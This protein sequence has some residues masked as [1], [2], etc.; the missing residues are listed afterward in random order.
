MKNRSTLLAIGLAIGL[1]GCASN[2]PSAEDD[3]IRFPDLESTYLREGDFVDPNDVLRI[4]EGQHKDQVRLL[5]GHP[6]FSEGIFGVR[7]WDY[8]FNFYTGYANEYITCQYKLLFDREMRVTSTHWRNA[9]CPVLLVPIQVEELAT[10]PRQER[11]TLSGDVLFGFDSN[12]LTFEGRR[13]LERVVDAFH[14]T[15]A[16]ASIR[17]AGYADR[18]GDEQYNLRLSQERAETVGN[19]LVN[20]GVERASLNMVGRGEADPI[21]EC[22]GQVATPSVRECLKPNR[23]VELTFQY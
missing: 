12:Q 18:F 14:G 10:E 13:A 17:V 8:A 6:H 22:P 5:L 11:L 9:Q 15:T 16:P 19:Y 4:S 2:S 23:R 21:V 7:E 1:A 20:Q 3:E